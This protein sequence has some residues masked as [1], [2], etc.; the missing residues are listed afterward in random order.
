MRVSGRQS[1]NRRQLHIAVALLLLLLSILG[2]GYSLKHSAWNAPNIDQGSVAVSTLNSL[3]ISEADDS[4]AVRW[5]SQRNRQLPARL[6]IRSQLRSVCA[7]RGYT[8]LLFCS[9]QT[10][11][12]VLLSGSLQHDEAF[13]TFY[14]R[15]WQRVLPARAGP[16]A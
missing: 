13:F 12:V 5:D 11:E 16:L 2:L 6:E 3:P 7:L 4:A 9:S 8:P 10:C 15:I 1:S 14:R